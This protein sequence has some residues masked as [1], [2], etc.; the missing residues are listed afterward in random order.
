METTITKPFDRQ[1]QS[2]RDGGHHCDKRGY[3]GT[4]TALLF[5]LRKASKYQLRRIHVVGDS[6]LILGN[7]RRRQS[8]KARHLQ[9]LY[10]QCRLAANQLTVATWRHHLR[11]YNRMAD[12]LAKIA[13]DTGRSIQVLG[14]DMRCLPPMWKEVTDNLRGDIGY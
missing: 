2:W 1:Q 12:K 5:G 7:L 3:A 13:M 9:D 8:P 14:R 10:R 6:D 11:L 4:T